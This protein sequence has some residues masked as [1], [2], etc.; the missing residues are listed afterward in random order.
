M[1]TFRVGLYEAI[2][3]FAT[4][5]AENKKEARAKAQQILDEDGIIGLMDDF[6]SHNR[7]TTVLSVEEDT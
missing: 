5:R 7:E 2:S 6:K 3:G 1:K 4:I